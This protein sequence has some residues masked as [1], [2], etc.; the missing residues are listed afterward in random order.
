MPPVSKVSHMD[1]NI[2]IHVVTTLHTTHAQ[3]MQVLRQTRIFV[4]VNPK[5]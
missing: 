1:Q 2:R 3:E 4:H 5:S